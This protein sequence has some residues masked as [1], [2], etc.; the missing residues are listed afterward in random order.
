[1][2]RFALAIPLAKTKQTTNALA[3]YLSIHPS[4]HLS[5]H[6]SIHPSIRPFTHES[7]NYHWYSWLLLNWTLG[8]SKLK[9]TGQTRTKIDFPWICY[10][11]LTQSK[12]VFPPWTFFGICVV[13]INCVLKPQ[14][15]QN[16]SMCTRRFHWQ[17]KYNKRTSW[18][19]NTNKETS[20]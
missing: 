10:I 1:M 16:G 6:S 3:I 20:K 5:I 8:S 15:A 9:Q 4:I 19:E 13:N 18:N 11:P 14:A 17:S 2:E 12:F 7:L